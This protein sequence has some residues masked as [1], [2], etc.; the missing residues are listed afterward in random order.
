MISVTI[1]R[2][3][4]EYRCFRIYAKDGRCLSDGDQLQ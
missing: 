1:L 4:Y 2:Y 3:I